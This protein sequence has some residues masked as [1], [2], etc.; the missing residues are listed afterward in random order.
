MRCIPIQKE[1][2]SIV[3][4]LKFPMSWTGAGPP[5]SVQSLQILV[6]NSIPEQ[7]FTTFVPLSEV[8]SDWVK[9]L[10]ALYRA[11]LIY[12]G[13]MDPENIQQRG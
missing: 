9:T 5:P 1:L 7:I 10:I 2:S 8:R 4:I 12:K 11:H 6:L 13:P 3:H